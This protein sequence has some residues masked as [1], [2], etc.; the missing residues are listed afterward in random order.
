[1]PAG[2]GSRCGRWR[3]PNG[4]C[5]RRDGLRPRGRGSWCS[6]PRRIARAKEADMSLGS[7]LRLGLAALTPC[8]VVGPLGGASVAQE[9]ERPAAE[10][11][12]DGDLQITRAAQTVR[13]EVKS[14]EKAYL[15]R[16]PR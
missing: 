8:L 14:P 3:A 16:G 7:K 2:P 12:R 1:M 5:W 6:G 9:P 4:R 13:L 11:L 10:A 15:V